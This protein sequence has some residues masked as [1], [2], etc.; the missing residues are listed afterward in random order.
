MLRC[1]NPAPSIPLSASVSLSLPLYLSP[2]LSSLYLSPPSVSISPLPYLSLAISLYLSPLSLSLSLSVSYS[3]TLSHSLSITPSLSH[4]LLLY[5]SLSLS[6]PFF[7][8]LSL[9]VPVV[10]Y[11]GRMKQF[12][13]L[14]SKGITTWSKDAVRKKGNWLNTINVRHEYRQYTDQIILERTT[15]LD[16]SCRTLFVCIRVSIHVTSNVELVITSDC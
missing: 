2:S 4:S 15:S 6:S 16:T 9:F 8:E 14:D 13:L 10:T 1:T 12:I 7:H 3:L 11:D 5:F